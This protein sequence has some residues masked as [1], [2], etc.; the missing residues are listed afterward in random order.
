MAQSAYALLAASADEAFRQQVV[1]ALSM[2]SDVAVRTTDN[3]HETIMAVLEEGVAAVILDL[4][5]HSLA[6]G[7]ATLEVLKKLHPRMPI[8]VVSADT[9]TATGT[10]VVEKGVFYYLFKPV[11]N[12]ELKEVVD[13]AIKH[14]D[15]NRKRF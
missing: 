13:N 7:L 9:S 15:K 12:I 11:N 3:G 6:D 4:D 14:L 2:R 5:L 10:R 1:E 8:I